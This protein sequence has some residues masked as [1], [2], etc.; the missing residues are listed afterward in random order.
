MILIIRIASICWVWVALF[1]G[2]TSLAYSQAAGK[3]QELDYSVNANTGIRFFDQPIDGNYFHYPLVVRAVD[4]HDPRINTAPMA[5]EG[6]LV[7]VSLPEMQQLL[8]ALAQS[9]VSWQR[10]EEVGMFGPSKE[11][12]ITGTMVITVVSTKGT[13]K[14]SL[15]PK[16]ICGTL[17]PLDHSLYAPRAVWEFQR[18]RL[19]YGCKVRNFVYDA[20]PDHY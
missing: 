8:K 18:F 1:T 14:A 2:T 20:Y 11:L 5:A 19:N 17:R 13:F 6:R 16:K 4:E 10:S 3:G 12:E 15:E 7:Y 9:R